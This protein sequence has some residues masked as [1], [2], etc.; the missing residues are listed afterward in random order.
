M[1]GF[2]YFKHLELDCHFCN[3]SL[4]LGPVAPTLPEAVTTSQPPSHRREV[5]EGGLCISSGRGLSLV[6][7]LQG[8][9][10]SLIPFGLGTSVNT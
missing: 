9:S 10:V 2:I 7:V 8:L 3:C 5:G 4:F 1:C 6:N